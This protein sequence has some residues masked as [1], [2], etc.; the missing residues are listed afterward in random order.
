MLVSPGEV[1]DA[2]TS[3]AAEAREAGS[4]LRSLP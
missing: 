2:I 3:L 4:S 1:A